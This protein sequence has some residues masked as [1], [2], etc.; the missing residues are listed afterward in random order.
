MMT[1]MLGSFCFVGHFDFLSAPHLLNVVGRGRVSGVEGRLLFPRHLKL[2]TR[3][4]LR[5]CASH[6][7][8]TMYTTLF[9]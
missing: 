8:D 9:P 7:V 2:V 5:P 4:S 3:I 1:R 6:G